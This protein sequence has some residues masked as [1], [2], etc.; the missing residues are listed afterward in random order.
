[1][2]QQENGIAFDISDVR[3]RINGGEYTLEEAPVY[4]SFWV[5]LRQIGILLLPLLLIGGIGLIGFMTSRSFNRRRA[6]NINFN[7]LGTVTRLLGNREALARKVLMTQILRGPIIVQKNFESDDKDERAANV[8]SQLQ[9]YDFTPEE[10]E[11]LV[12]LYMTGRIQLENMDVDYHKVKPVSRNLM[13]IVDG[14]ETGAD[15]AE[16]AFIRK[17]VSAAK[18]GLPEAMVIYDLLSKNLISTADIMAAKDAVKV[19]R[20]GQAYGSALRWRKIVRALINKVETDALEA[21]QRGDVSLIDEL[22]ATPQ[23]QVLRKI[24]ERVDVEAISSRAQG[25]TKMT[26]FVQQLL[27]E[28]NHPSDLRPRC[29]RRNR[30]RIR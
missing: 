14:E 22:P 28:R 13:A 17:L 18:A 19:N 12:R 3:V 9:G 7:N 4:F 5:W 26:T 24:I 20:H 8:R 23:V 6:R 1:M 21:I 25:F 2:A 11:V 27:R 10:I 30:P 29:P 15:N 16:A